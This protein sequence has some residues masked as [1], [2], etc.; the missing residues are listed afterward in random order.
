MLVY[1]RQVTATLIYIL[2]SSPS[3]VRIK[4]YASVNFYTVG[5]KRWPL[6]Y[7]YDNFHFTVALRN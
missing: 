5:H 3:R 6:F 2:L 1:R 7:F 4:I